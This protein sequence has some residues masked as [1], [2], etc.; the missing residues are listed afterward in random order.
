MYLVMADA[1]SARGVGQSVPTL[2]SMRAG[3]T[4]VSYHDSATVPAQ[5]LSQQP[6]QLAVSVV[7][8]AVATSPSTQRVD[9]VPQSQ[10]GSVDVR[11]F[12]QPLTSVL[13]TKVINLCLVQ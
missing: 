13:Y 10:Q 3:R 7:D 2:V 1:I 8:V 6:G 5:R 9:H 4:D 11:S 12:K